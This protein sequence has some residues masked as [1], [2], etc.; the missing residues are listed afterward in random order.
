MLSGDS[1]THDS[2]VR[3]HDLI[4]LFPSRDIGAELALGGHEIPDAAGDHAP[5]SKQVV[6]FSEDE[7]FE[8]L[9]R[10]PAL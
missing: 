3:T 5:F 8:A 7:W 1:L 9:R 6:E 10:E 2:R 4:A